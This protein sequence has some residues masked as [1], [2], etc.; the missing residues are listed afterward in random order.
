M[1]YQEEQDAFD[2]NNEMDTNI[3]ENFIGIK[4]FEQKN[5]N[6][7]KEYS[8]TF[9]PLVKYIRLLKK[10]HANKA[11]VE[12][13]K[14]AKEI[15]KVYDVAE[16]QEINLNNLKEIQEVKSMLELLTSYI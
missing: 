16:G 14:V 5:V 8:A 12:E 9:S 2:V 6:I 7:R 4:E 1:A 11:N 13:K 15:Q 10:K 3:L